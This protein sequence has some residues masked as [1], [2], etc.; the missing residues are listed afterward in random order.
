MSPENRNQE[1]LEEFEIFMKRDAAVPP[2]SVSHTVLS[3]VIVVKM[4][5]GF[6]IHKQ[7]SFY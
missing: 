4:T 1:W 5:K 6:S 2:H 3:K 7:G